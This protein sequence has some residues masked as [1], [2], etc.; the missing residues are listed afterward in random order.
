[1]TNQRPTK[2]DFADLIN[3]VMGRQVMTEQQ[4]DQFLH[5]AKRVKDNQGTDGL[6]EYIQ[7][8]TNAPAS[9]DQLKGLAEQIQKTGSAGSALDFLMKERLIS[10]SQAKK[11]N[12]ALEQTAKKKR[13]K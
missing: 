2:K 1:M 3:T 11:L 7:K 13:K 4:L 6:V 12:K 9:K 10:E 5:E 8:I